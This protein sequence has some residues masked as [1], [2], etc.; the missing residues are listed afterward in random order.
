MS[1]SSKIITRKKIAE[2][3]GVT[4]A[5]VTFALSDHTAMKISAATRDRIRKIA[6]E[7]HYVPNFMSRALAVRKSF[8]IAMI[9]PPTC[10]D[11]I[12]VQHLKIFHGLSTILEAT[13][14]VLNVFF[15]VSDKFVEK[16][17]AGRIDGVIIVDSVVREEYFQ[18]LLPLHLALATANFDTDYAPAVMSDHAGAL[19]ESIQLLLRRGCRKIRYIYSDKPAIYDP[20][21]IPGLRE[22]STAWPEALLDSW[23][24]QDF[25]SLTPQMCGMPGDF[26]GF[27]VNGD[28]RCRYIRNYLASQGC[29]EGSDYRLVL[30]DN[31]PVPDIADSFLQTPDRIGSAVWKTVARLL[32][33]ETVPPVELIPYQYYRNGVPA[34]P[35]AELSHTISS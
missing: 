22:L 33:G 10:V 29:R 6:A 27:V 30:L 4:P 26:D 34:S 8:N 16:A 23:K 18:R 28:F 31:R 9:L 13:D 5:M 15:G 17:K 1:S 12:S 2:L 32:D 7:H 11:S 24:I 21:V 20:V 3:A 14:Y 25:L 35:P 19:R